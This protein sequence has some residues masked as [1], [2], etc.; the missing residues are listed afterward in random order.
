MV[1][2]HMRQLK[3]KKRPTDVEMYG[4]LGYI[5]LRQPDFWEEHFTSI[6]R[7]EGYTKQL[8][9]E[10]NYLLSLFTLRP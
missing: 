3:L 9:E 2:S 4:L 7:V 1:T 8:A 5:V 10:G 6:F